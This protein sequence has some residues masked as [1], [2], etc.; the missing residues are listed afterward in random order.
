MGVFGKVA[1]ASAGRKN[2][3]KMD[4]LG[5]FYARF[6]NTKYVAGAKGHFAIAEC[7]VIQP[8]DEVYKEG[9]F[10]CHMQSGGEHGFLEQFMAGYVAAYNNVAVG[11]KFSENE[12]ENED[13]WDKKTQEIFGTPVPEDGKFI[14]KHDNHL[15]G[16]VGHWKIVEDR[17]E[18]R[19]EEKKKRDADGNVIVYKKVVFV[20][21]VGPDEID[22]EVLEKELP[23]LHFSYQ[24]VVKEAP[25]DPESE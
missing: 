16:V 13:I 4:R 12:T 24:P 17:Q 9:D 1:K 7:T 5:S 25:E 11:H 21:L 22:P 18:G 10:L 3:G 14:Y 20:G 2:A 15:K 8:H 6:E 19:K 23:N